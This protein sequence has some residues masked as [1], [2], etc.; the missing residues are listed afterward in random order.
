[1]LKYTLKR[2]LM[3]IPVILGIVTIVFVLMRVFSSNPAY[4]L[5]GQ[6]ALLR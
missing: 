6:R 3:A 1:M 2:I 5:L 4:L